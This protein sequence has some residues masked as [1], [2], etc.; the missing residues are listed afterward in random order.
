MDT[1]TVVP[2]GASMRSD[3]ASYLHMELQALDTER[4]V[5]AWAVA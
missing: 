3:R 5:A 4:S 2:P 1:T